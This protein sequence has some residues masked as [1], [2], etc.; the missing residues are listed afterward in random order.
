MGLPKIVKL[1]SVGSWHVS[2]S[3]S[4][5]T[6]GVL[7]T[8]DTRESLDNDL[9]SIAIIRHGQPDEVYYAW[10]FTKD[11][12][13]KLD[14][15]HLISSMNLLDQERLGLNDESILQKTM[16]AL[17]QTLQGLVKPWK[18]LIR[19]AQEKLVAQHV[20]GEAPPSILLDPKLW[21]IIDNNLDVKIKEDSVGRGTTFLMECTAFQD[22]P[23][24]VLLLGESSI[25]KTWLA[26]KSA[27]LLPQEH[28]QII[29]SST[30]RAWFY[31]GEPIYEQGK[32]GKK[33]LAHY[34]I[35]WRNTV[36][37]ILDNVDE[38]TIRDL[39]P[40]MSHDNFGRTIDIQVSMKT[41]GGGYRRIIVKVTGCPSFVNCSTK[42]R[43]NEELS[44]RHFFV[45]PVDSHL[46][47]AASLKYVG[48]RD[49]KGKEPDL[50]DGE[51]IRGALG[52]LIDHNIK[53]V[54]AEDVEA[55]VRGMF[56]GR[57]AREVR[58]FERILTLVKTHGW[59]HALQREKNEGGAIIA[60]KQDLTAVEPL[61]KDMLKMSKYSTSAQVI[62]FYEKVLLPAVPVEAA[63]DPSKLDSAK[64]LDFIQLTR[65]QIAKRYRTQYNRTMS[66]R[67]LESY[68]E[69]L[70]GLGFLEVDPDPNDKRRR[71][72][73]IYREAV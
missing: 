59:L 15:E 50:P 25:G 64:T 26:Q 12:L 41:R 53:A 19:E 42:L 1:Q 63:P 68:L 62:D 46:K 2:T 36:V 40:V 30:R 29:G 67:L 66:W 24:H 56:P 73:T 55:E 65:K 11:E 32:D 28:V 48:Q 60:D 43:W 52:W 4:S 45:T 27:E 14:S 9:A 21:E 18:A 61:I 33:H 44:T 6:G 10:T 23:A 69:T 37:I 34:E 71:I 17:S 57:A 47:Y 5:A 31:C 20:E 35:D 13:T 22:R 3:G 70:E 72:Y 51:R 58:D 54:I 16:N 38:N 8:L 49:M 39:K 7:L